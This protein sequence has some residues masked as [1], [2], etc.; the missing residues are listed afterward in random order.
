[1]PLSQA[2]NAPGVPVAYGD[3]FMAGKAPLKP[4][5]SGH[6]PMSEELPCR[7]KQKNYYSNLRSKEGRKKKKSRRGRKIKDSEMT[8]KYIF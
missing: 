3:G 2:T 5:V 1:M 8:I 7:E 4:G 6:N